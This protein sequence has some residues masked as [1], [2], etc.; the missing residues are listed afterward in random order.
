MTSA[1]PSE[2]DDPED[3]ENLSGRKKKKKRKTTRPGGSRSQQA[4]A[5]ATSKIQ[6]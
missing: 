6:G 5:M 4:K 2:N 1:S 3:P